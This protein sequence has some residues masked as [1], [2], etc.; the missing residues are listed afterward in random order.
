MVIVSNFKFCCKCRKN[1]LF[2]EASEIKVLLPFIDERLCD[3]ENIA[4]K[5]GDLML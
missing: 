3:N 5:R 1:V 2:D 4:D